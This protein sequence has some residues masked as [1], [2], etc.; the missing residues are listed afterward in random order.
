[1]TYT[2]PTPST[3][4]AGDTFPA[5]AYN[6]ISADLQDHE[7]RIKTG[8]E[9]YTTAQKTALTSVA[10]GTV[11]YDST[12]GVMQMW[13]GSAWVLLSGETKISSGSI[14]IGLVATSGTYLIP[15][16]ATTTFTRFRLYIHNFLNRG[17][18]YVRLANGST[19]DSSTNYN[20][21]STSS[22]TAGINH[23]G[24]IIR[25][26]VSSTGLNTSIADIVNPNV[27]LPTA[28]ITRYNSPALTLVTGGAHT[29]YV[30]YDTICLWVDSTTTATTPWTLFGVA[31]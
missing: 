27:N 15:L 23:M 14:P 16:T 18:V 10:T 19:V 28:L 11:I 22:L 29:L 30:S 21:T 13:N 3:V 1:V 17:S 5:S 7:T 25:G 9:S 12:L 6:I 26:D 2:T 4:S 20:I 24:E 31:T 8:V